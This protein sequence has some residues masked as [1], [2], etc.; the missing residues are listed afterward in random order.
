MTAMTITTT[1][2]RQNEKVLLRKK[3]KAEKSITKPF[4]S[5]LFAICGTSWMIFMRMRIRLCMKANKFPAIVRFFFCI[6][7]FSMLFFY[8]PPP[9]HTD[10]LPLSLNLVLSNHF[11]FF[12]FHCNCCVQ[13]TLSYFAFVFHISIY[14]SA[15]STTFIMYAHYYY[16]LLLFCLCSFLFVVDSYAVNASHSTHLFCMLL[17]FCVRSSFTHS[18]GSATYFCEIVYFLHKFIYSAAYLFAKKKK[19]SSLYTLYKAQ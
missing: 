17:L 1:S 5:S 15:F 11:N 10:S 16:L 2:V 3:M 12:L 18:F 6:P 13:C 7:S 8:S 4:K 9:C 14:F 19:Q